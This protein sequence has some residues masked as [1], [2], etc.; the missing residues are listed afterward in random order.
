MIWHQNISKVTVIEARYH[1]WLTANNYENT[2]NLISQLETTL[3]VGNFRC[4]DATLK[5]YFQAARPI[6]VLCSSVVISCHA[7]II[8]SLTI[9]YQTKD[10][11]LASRFLHLPA[12]FNQREMVIVRLLYD[13]LYLQSKGINE[14]G[15]I[16]C[17]I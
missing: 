13:I 11:G 15:Q 9:L 6:P 5:Q 14:V 1:N 3:K 7:E 12:G 10:R 17:A 8:N 4:I 16:I 2:N